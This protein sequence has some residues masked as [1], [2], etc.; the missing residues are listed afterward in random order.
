MRKYGE[1]AK[2]A[3]SITKEKRVS[4]LQAWIQ[5]AEMIFPY[6]DS[7]QKKGCPKGAFLGLASAGRILGIPRDDYGK[8]GSGKNASYAIAA[9]DIIQQNPGIIAQGAKVLWQMS[10]EKVGAELDKRSN[11]QMEV[12]LALHELGLLQ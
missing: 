11:S 8:S 1:V 10:L 4:P 2:L 7:S 5:A 3:V 9:A 12:V 6:S